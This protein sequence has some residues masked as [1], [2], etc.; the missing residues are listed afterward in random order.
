MPRVP[1]LTRARR[2]CAPRHRGLQR[3]TR[4]CSSASA[5]GPMT[6]DDRLVQPSLNENLPNNVTT[7]YW[8]HYKCHPESRA[9]FF[10]YQKQKIFWNSKDWLIWVKIK[11]ILHGTLSKKESRASMC[12]MM[13]LANSSFSLL[14]GGGEA[15]GA[16]GGNTR[17]AR[18]TNERHSVSIVNFK[19]AIRSHQFYS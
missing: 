2:P 13:V 3:N 1:H 14:F 15:A 5:T 19:L 16:G 10:N 9:V 7:C 8:N 4:H 11:K 17:Q 6:S 18:K 12:Q